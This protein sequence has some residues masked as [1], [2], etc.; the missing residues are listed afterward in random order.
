MLS[1]KHWGMSMAFMTGEV[2]AT[3]GHDKPFMV[4]ITMG[5]E[6]RG[7]WSVESQEEGERLIVAALSHIKEA[8]EAEGGL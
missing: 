5:G 2:V 3:P 7:Q 1:G 4:V 6:I 8:M